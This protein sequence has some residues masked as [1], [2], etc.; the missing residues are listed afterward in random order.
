MPDL[1][2]QRGWSQLEKEELTLPSNGSSNQCRELVIL[3]DT[4]DSEARNPREKWKG[5][6]ETI[7]LFL[8]L[9]ASMQG[10]AYFLGV[11]RLRGGFT[12]GHYSGRHLIHVQT[13]EFVE[14]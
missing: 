3:G 9:E 5:S 13:P 12:I 1:N 2:F 8:K 6:F 4:L 11:G 14:S 10:Y 7:W